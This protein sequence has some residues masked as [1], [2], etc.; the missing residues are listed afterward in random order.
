MA[1][2]GSAVKSATSK[3]NQVAGHARDLRA[4]KGSPVW[5][6][7]KN[8]PKDPAKAAW[9]E[10]ARRERSSGT[11]LNDGGDSLLNSPL[12]RKLQ[13]HQ[14]KRFV[15]EG[16]QRG[17]QRAF[18]QKN[19]NQY[20]EMRRNFSAK[21]QYKAQQRQAR[22]EAKQGRG[23]NA[24]QYE[25]QMRQ[26]AKANGSGPR[27]TQPNYQSSRNANDAMRR[28]RESAEARKNLRGRVLERRKATGSDG[29][30]GSAGGANG[31]SNNANGGNGPGS[32]KQGAAYKL[33]PGGDSS[34]T[35][36][37]Q[38]MKSGVTMRSN[39]GDHIKSNYGGKTSSYLA[40]TAGQGAVWGGAIGGTV[41]AAQGGDFWEGAKEG[42]FKGA[43]GYTGYKSLKVGT[44]SQSASEILDNGKMIWQYHGKGGAGA[45]VQ[46]QQ[47]LR[48]NVQN[49][50]M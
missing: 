1:G 31:P 30:G 16:I 19:A 13:Q 34:E 5:T 22:V 18:D 12:K 46:A 49:T 42:A 25:Y 37:E 41:S 23:V 38:V 35:F 36:M 50:V 26:Q 21:D 39:I 15:N 6:G 33:E 11:R 40:R 43:V 24:D 29:P 28:E 8:I 14:N 10:A 7:G 45:G 32:T 3:L 27:R 44:K 48:Q 9:Q 20:E 47:V 17:R 4:G 2:V